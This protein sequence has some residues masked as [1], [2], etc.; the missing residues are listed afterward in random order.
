MCGG[1]I[2]MNPLPGEMMPAQFGP[3]RRIFFSRG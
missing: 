1:M 3:I 2:P